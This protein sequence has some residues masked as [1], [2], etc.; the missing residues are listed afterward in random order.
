MITGNS[1]LLVI[2]IYVP[3]SPRGNSSS[4]GR[5]GLVMMVQNPPLMH[6]FQGSGM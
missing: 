3:A 1:F 5:F 4:E 2:D 6:V